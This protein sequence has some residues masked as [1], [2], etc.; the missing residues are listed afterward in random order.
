[1]RMVRFFLICM[2]C[3][4]CRFVGAQEVPHSWTNEQRHLYFGISISLRFY[5]RDD[6]L[7]QDIWRYLEGIDD[8][9][10]DY[11]D[12]SEI[13]VINASHKKS[14][15][16]SSQ[17]CK[18]FIMADKLRVL[19]HGYFD[20][21]VGP[22]RRLWKGAARSGRY[23]SDAELSAALAVVGPQHY[24]LDKSTLH[25]VNP[26]VSFDFGALIKGMALDHVQGMLAQHKVQSALVQV[27]GETLCFG[28]SMLRAHK[29]HR[30]GIPNPDDPEKLWTVIADQGNGLSICTSANYRQPIVIN[31]VV[32]YHI[33]N[34]QTGRPGVTHI[35]SVSVLFPQVG[36]NGLCDG[37]ATAGVLMKPA[38]FLPL[39]EE[40]GAEG[41]VLTRSANGEIMQQQT[42]GWRAYELGSR[43]PKK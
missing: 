13:G 40:M 15:V 9:F 32:Y 3:V 23:P 8:I 26:A 29:K 2:V 6:A 33:F 24:R 19:S 34:P 12:D 39:L 43:E 21:T 28:S 18:A 11:R 30:L 17:L 4:P 37:L 31:D 14:Y 41:M 42:R 27:G 25:I 22:L 16:V 36:M 38:V 10:N 7:A 20:I 1:M 5:P 35:L